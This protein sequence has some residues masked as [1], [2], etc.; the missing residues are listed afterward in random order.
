LILVNSIQRKA[1]LWFFL[2]TL[3]IAFFF[4]PTYAQGNSAKTGSLI[5]RKTQWADLK[6]HPQDSHTYNEFWTYHFLLNDSLQLMVN[7][8]RANMGLFKDPV[9]GADLAIKGFK[10]ENY[11]VAREYPLKKFIWNHQEQGL[12]VHPQIWFKGALPQQHELYF[13]TT[14]NK[15]TSTVHLTFEEIIPG[16]VLGKGEHKIKGEKIGVLLHIARAR[17]RG[18]IALN[19]DTLQVEGFG[20]LDHTYQSTLGTKLAE[21]IFRYQKFSYPA[22]IAYWIQTKH[23]NKLLGFQVSESSP[24]QFNLLIPQKW[25]YQKE[26]EVSGVSLPQDISLVLKIAPNG[27]SKNYRVLLEHPDYSHSVLAEFK[28]FTKSAIKTFMGGELI[29]LRGKGSLNNQ[30]IHYQYSGIR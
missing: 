13:N 9:C 26:K 17:V 21:R 7:F 4:S 15:V 27:E 14:K 30:K 18:Y 24:G 1:I 20:T 16:L 23:D 6:D 2:S 10:G 12:Q 22:E 8:S 28:G 19:G 29:F 5:P 11:T 25:E 3:A